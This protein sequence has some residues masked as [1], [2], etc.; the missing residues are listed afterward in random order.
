MKRRLRKIKKW[1]ARRRWI[2]FGV[3]LPA[4]N[5]RLMDKVF[6]PAARVLRI[7]RRLRR[8]KKWFARRQW[9]LL[10]PSL[11]AILALSLLVFGALAV[12]FIKHQQD[13]L[14]RRYLRQAGAALAAGNFEAARVACLRGLAAPRTERERADWMFYLAVSLN[15]LGQTAEANGL[16][17]AAAPLNHP[18]SPEGHV[19]VAQSLLNSTNLNPETL[20]MAE[21]HLLNALAVDPKSLAANEML[22]RFYINTRKFNQ[23]RANLLKVY[24]AKPDTALLVAI[25]F[26]LEKNTNS[27]MLWTERAIPAI[28]KNL[29]RSAAKSSATERLSLLQALSIKAK[30]APLPDP[31][32]RA[33][34]SS[35][36]AAPQDAPPVWLDLVRSLV[37]SEKY[38]SALATLDH[39][40]MVSPSPVYPP[41]IA[42]VCAAWVGNFPRN[43]N[44]ERL[45]VI[46]KG[47]ANAPRNLKLRWLLIQATH[48]RDDSGAVAQNTLAA[49]M[50]AV[51]GQSA[52]FWHFLIATDCRGRGDLPAAR[53]HLQAAYELSPDIPEIQ[54]DMAWELLSGNSPDLARALKLVQSA[55]EKFPDNP[56]F[57]DTRGRVLAKLGRPAEA[58]AD[59]GFAANHLT[60]TDAK[61][62]L[63]LLAQ[64]NV[65]MGKKP[66]VLPEAATALDNIPK[67]LDQVHN[68]LTEGKYAAALETLDQGMAINPNPAYAAAIAEACVTS[69]NKIPPAQKTRPA[70]RLRLIQKGLGQ[71][72]EHLK[73]RVL[74]VQAA[75]AST[76]AAPAANKLLDQLVS[77]STGDSAAGWQL[78][79]GQE[80]RSRG[81]AAVARQHFQTACKLAPYLT[82]AKYEL[83]AML[84]AGPRSD[85]ELGVQLMNAVVD[86]FPTRPDY[87]QMRGL[88]LFRLERHE[89]AVVDLKLAVDHIPHSSETRLALAKAYD[90]LGKTQL[91][92]QQRRLAKIGTPAQ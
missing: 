51:P 90:A 67:R 4:L 52:A 13:G 27:A 35:T 30:Y 88:L 89:A 86:E 31:L 7:K 12:F 33:M 34:L 39:A 64:V 83:A 38:S 23:A 22:G 2:V 85:W 84:A 79:L 65:A 11:P 62:T 32:E 6:W 9:K 82:Q 40:A 54:N 80:A 78:L 77:A 74:L 16:L 59:L 44:A 87:R 8:I 49:E 17:A 21:R 75:Y 91:A 5:A 92:E 14:Q 18:G 20:R 3:D 76:E 81:D 45:K 42:D 43:Q 1:F 19:M 46:Q 50:A 57:R 60:G 73:L 66:A 26:D 15:G 61:E 37:N 48:A 63:A 70:E 56:N 53:Q 24:P 55:L 69:V 41:V 47:L 72:P 68:L 28:R 36:N 10:W 71:V 25:S 29:A 58:A